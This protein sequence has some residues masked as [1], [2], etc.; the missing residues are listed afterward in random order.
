[1]IN[2]NCIC[3][4]CGASFQLSYELPLGSA[5]DVPTAE[6]CD[7]CVAEGFVP[8]AE[9]YASETPDCSPAGE[10]F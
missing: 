5:A 7:T 3:A 8:A 10:R 6:L 2:I 1:M 4:V 9:Y